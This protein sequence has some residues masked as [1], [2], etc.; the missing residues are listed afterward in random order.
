MVEIFIKN[1]SSNQIDIQGIKIL[2]E[3]LKTN[4]TLLSL[5]LNHNSIKDTGAQDLSYVPPLTLGAVFVSI[6][7]IPI[8]LELDGN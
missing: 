1:L 5:N 3:A 8:T 7:S 2:T 4:N 6:I